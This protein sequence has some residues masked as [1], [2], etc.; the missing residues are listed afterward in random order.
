MGEEI[1][2]RD[3]G[4]GDI[5]LELAEHFTDGELGE[6]TSDEPLPEEPGGTR[7]RH[8][9]V[10]DLLFP[11]V[12]LELF[13]VVPVGLF[14]L[15]LCGVKVLEDEFLN[16]VGG[17]QRGSAGIKVFEDRL[18]ILGGVELDVHDA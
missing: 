1:G 16:E 11:P 17:G 10:G 18:S 15:V 3:V 7:V 8:P 2:Y 13:P 4:G 6:G 12:G 14:C 9:T 5:L